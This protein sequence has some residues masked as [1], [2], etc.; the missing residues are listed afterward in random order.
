M[1]NGYHVHLIKVRHISFFLIRVKTK[2]RKI[3]KEVLRRRTEIVTAAAVP[4][5]MAAVV[6]VVVVYH[7]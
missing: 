2:L 7:F 1:I 3:K 4:P 5:L 6:V